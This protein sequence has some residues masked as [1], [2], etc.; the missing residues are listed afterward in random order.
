[1]D[2]YEIETFLEHQGFSDEE[3]DDFL[4][5]FGKKGMKWGVRSKTQKAGITGAALLSVGAAQLVGA[6]LG[7][8]DPRLMGAISVGA[9]SAGALAT[10]RILDRQGKT[11]VS[12]AATK[13]S[14]TR[15]STTGE[16]VLV[17]TTGALFA[18]A[19]I[20]SFSNLMKLR[21]QFS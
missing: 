15:K 9:L 8:R 4:E 6:K 10:G 1:M 7:V 18:A 21:E 12:D 16:K 2:V 17:V 13:T 20:K 19:W 14:K 11:K 3:I 5:H